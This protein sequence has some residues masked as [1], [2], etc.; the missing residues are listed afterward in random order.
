M[1]TYSRDKLQKKTLLEKNYNIEG[2]FFVTETVWISFKSCT[3]EIEWGQTRREI[4][5]FTFCFSTL[6]PMFLGTPKVYNNSK[7]SWTPVFHKFFRIVD[8]LLFSSYKCSSF[9]TW[10]FFLLKQE[11][12]ANVDTVYRYGFY[13]LC[14]K[15]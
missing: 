5:I 3:N 7:R 8:F 1:T 10:E 4:L 14:N 15:S 2:L 13:E 11:F 12:E 9:S 6:R